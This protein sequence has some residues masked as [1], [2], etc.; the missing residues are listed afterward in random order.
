[1]RQF[2]ALATTA[3]ALAGCATLTLP[4]LAK[5]VTLS[6]NSYDHT[7]GAYVLEL[8]NNTPRAILYLNSYLTFHVVRSPDPEPFPTSSVEGLVL[9]AHDTKLDPGS[10]ITFSGQCT[11]AGACSRPDTYAAVNACWF[12]M[13]W[14]C[15]EYLPIWSETPLNGT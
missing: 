10:S 4:P 14:T 7:T 6:V 13:V 5:D 12:T 15:K 9:M 8:R 2:L 1:M 3:L 11:A